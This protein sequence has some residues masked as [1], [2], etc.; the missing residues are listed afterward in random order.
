[1]DD[2]AYD[3]NLESIMYGDTVNIFHNFVLFSNNSKTC[4][5]VNYKISKLYLVLV[6]V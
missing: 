4:F 2:R 1:M 6:D 5:V 3:N